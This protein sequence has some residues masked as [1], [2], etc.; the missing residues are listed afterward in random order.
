MS[1]PQGPG[2]APDQPEWGKG[3]AG[4]WGGAGGQGEQPDI[5]DDRTRPVTKEDVAAAAE[6]HQQAPGGQPAGGQPGDPRHGQ[7][8]GWGAQGGGQPQYGQ[9][10]YGDQ[11]QGWG[12]GYGQPGGA[13]QYG[14]QQGYG[15]PGQQQQGWGAP[16]GGQPQYGQ[17]QGY[18]GQYGQQQPGYGGQQQ[19]WGGQ[20]QQGWGQPGQQQGWGGDQGQP[21]QHWPGDPQQQWGG[22]GGYPPLPNAPAQGGGRSKL[23]FIV[24]G[25]VVLVLAAVGVLGFVTPGFFVT[26]VFDTQAVQAGVQKVLTDEYGLTVESVTCGQNIRVDNG[27]TFECDATIDGQPQKVP[28]K[29][30]SADG[31]YEVGRPA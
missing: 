4:G 12:G 7:Q 18:G 2:Q 10:G 31:D 15:Q 16:G 26:K 3:P 23:P 22:G 9:Q 19:G 28:V 29:V 24:A 14:Q 6:R 1:T 17:Q 20:E 13:P 8:Q 25:V 5:D 27:A 21:T 30:T 11:Q